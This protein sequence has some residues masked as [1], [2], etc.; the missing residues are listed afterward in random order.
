MDLN[1]YEMRLGRAVIESY[2]STEDVQKMRELLAENSP[3]SLGPDQK[4]VIRA[5]FK[6]LGYM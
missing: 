5:L 3:A 6:A 2:L 1:D 4:A